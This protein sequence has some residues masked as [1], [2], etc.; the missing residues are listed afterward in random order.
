MKWTNAPRRPP[1][2]PACARFRTPAECIALV[3][4]LVARCRVVDGGWAVDIS[5]AA[6]FAVGVGGHA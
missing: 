4:R 1:D 3:G 2:L 6:W 5:A